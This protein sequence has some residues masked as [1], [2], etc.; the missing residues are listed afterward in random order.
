MVLF[1][2]PIHSLH[3]TGVFR[4]RAGTLADDDRLQLS[5]GQQLHQRLRLRA[6]LSLGK[7]PVPLFAA[8]RILDAGEMHMEP[9]G[10]LVA[11]SLAH[12]VEDGGIVGFALDAAQRAGVQ[13]AEVDAGGDALVC[14]LY[15]S[16]S[17]RD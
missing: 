6:E 10:P 15:T 13:V 1:C 7:G 14:L 11:Q 5:L 8:R 2:F 4:L 3:R 12:T 17:P 9:L 16:P